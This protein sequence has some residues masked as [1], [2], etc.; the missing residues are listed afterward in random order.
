MRSGQVS[1][2]QAK[3]QE[4]AGEE[5]GTISQQ[6]IPH[7][8][9]RHHPSPKGMA[10]LHKIWPQIQK[11]CDNQQLRMQKTAHPLKLVG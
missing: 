3:E 4:T 7:K 9:Q 6:L 10:V 11:R 1:F 8:E 5:E 2:V